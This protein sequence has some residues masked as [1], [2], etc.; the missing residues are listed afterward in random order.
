MPAQTTSAALLGV[1]AFE[2][3]IEADIANGL[4]HLL[5]VGLPDAAVQE[6]RERVRA[7]LQN[8]DLPFPMRRVVINLAPAD[9]RKEGPAFDLPIALALL[10]AQR[11]LPPDSLS[12]T[13]CVGELAL[14]GTLR[15]VRGA[16]SIGLLAAAAGI[17]RVIVPPENAAEVAAVAG[18]EVIAPRSLVEIVSF[19]RGLI[20]LQTVAAQPPER[21]PPGPDLLDVRGQ[22]GAKRALEVAAAGGHNLLMT[23]PPGA[24]KTMLASRFPGLLPDLVD[25]EAV[26]ATRVHSAAGL[27]ARGLLVRPPFR[28]P[29]HTV[30][31]A[32][33]IGGGGTPRPGEVSLAHNGVLFLD[34]FGEFSRGVLEA[35]RQ[36]LEDGVVT[37]SRARG[38]LTF[39]ASFLLVASRNPCPCGYHGDPAQG[40]V[41]SPALLRRYRD[42]ISGP[43]LDRIDIRI[44]VPRVS[45]EDTLGSPKGP[46]SA[47]IRSRVARARLLARERQGVVNARLGGSELRKQCMLD[48][49]SESFARHVI[50]QTAISG[51][52]FDRLLR[53]ARTV[54]DLAGGLRICEEHLAEAV[55]Y[56]EAHA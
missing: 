29:H 48:A 52:G 14:D 13:I 46:D 50:A 27:P 7:A 26:E 37:I 3:R 9:V 22:A 38:S 28:Q 19:L 12:G 53:V 56:R 1:E 39:P 42:R 51:R 20:T 35:L 21:P 17:R 41:C 54:A 5:I 33:L 31:Y 25:Q 30:S 16:V 43:L 18:V 34:E 11:A 2:V 4:P 49:R 32:G 47:A 55:G 40:C 15:P 10:L 45:A 6:S 44:T 24:G 8:A 36:P 23:G